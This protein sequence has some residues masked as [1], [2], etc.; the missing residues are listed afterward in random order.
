MPDRLA[1]TLFQRDAAPGLPA[2]VCTYVI[3]ERLCCPGRRLLVA[4]SGGPDSVALLHLL[5]RLAPSLGLSLGVAHFDH[6]LRG[7]ASRE[8]ARF[9]ARLAGE[10]GFP[11]HLDQGDVQALSRARKI[12]RQMA[13]RELR[14]AFFRDVCQRHGY[15]QTALGHTADDQVELFFLRLLRGAGLSGLK[16][17]WPASP[18]GL[19]RPLLAVGKEVILAWL[20]Q[21]GLDFR[22]DRSNLSLGYPRNRVRLELIPELT[23]RYNPRLKAGVWRLMT[24]L[25]EDERLILAAMD[26]TWPEVAREPA[27]DLIVLSLPGLL[28]LPPALQGRVI[29]A[30]VSRISHGLALTAGQ[31]ENLLALARGRQSG[32]QITLPGCAIAR[33][34]AEL[35]FLRP[36]PPPPSRPATA[37]LEEPGTLE[38][39][40]GWRW[41][42]ARR[43]KPAEPVAQAPD[44]AW[45]DAAPVEFPLELRHPQ[46]GDRFW[47]AGTPGARKLQDFLVNRKIPRWL[48]PHL[49]LAV[50]RGQVLWVPGGRTA[51]PVKVGSDTAEVLMLQLTP[52]TPE[53]RRVWEY[54][55]TFVPHGTLPG[56][57]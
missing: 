6:G 20:A 28:A 12:S 39:A 50:S 1:P 14:R 34:G 45:L 16:G 41:V 23:Q 29:Q 51:Q 35:H 30:A 40:S 19:I 56:A 18:E 11:F 26:R 27:P 9:V 21:E 5:A 7:E 3:R 2:F 37:W 52:S 8:D 31:V 33:A 48:R 36:L 54:L 4:V 57:V 32:G 13:A 53:T 49:P 43:P 10:L 24:L 17:M 55:M 38:T 46:P 47:P 22:E 15:D 42:A 25:Q 44:T